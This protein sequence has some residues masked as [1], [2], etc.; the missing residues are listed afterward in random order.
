MTEYVALKLPQQHQ[1]ISQLVRPFNRFVIKH[2]EVTELGTD[3]GDRDSGQG[4]RGQY[5]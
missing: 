4:F 5:I 1:R 3:S 2:H